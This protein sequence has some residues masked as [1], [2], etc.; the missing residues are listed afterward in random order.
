MAL[1]KNNL[2]IHFYV[3][4]VI[5]WSVV[6]IVDTII[7]EAFQAKLVPYYETLK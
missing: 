4:D 2:L 7:M 6:D 5:Y 1:K 3:M